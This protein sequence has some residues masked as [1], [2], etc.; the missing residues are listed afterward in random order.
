MQIANTTFTEDT[1][2]LEDIDRLTLEKT[3]KHATAD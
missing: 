3:I 2:E 1:M